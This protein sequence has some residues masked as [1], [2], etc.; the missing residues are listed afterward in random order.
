MRRTL[1]HERR[2]A[3]ASQGG[4]LRK[5]W[6]ILVVPPEQPPL[7]PSPASSSGISLWHGTT[8]R[9]ESGMLLPLEP[10]FA[11]QVQ[12]IAQEFALPSISGL[13]LYL[14]LPNGN[15]HDVPVPSPYSPALSPNFPSSLGTARYD[16]GYST[17]PRLTE[18]TW[19]ILWYDFLYPTSQAGSTSGHFG[20]PIAGRI[21]FDVDPSRARWQPPWLGVPTSD[22]SVDA[23][24]WSTSPRSTSRSAARFGTSRSYARSAT[25][26]WNVA[27]A[28]SHEVSDKSE[29]HPTIDS[30]FN[31]G[32][33]RAGSPLSHR[34]PLSLLSHGSS[35]VRGPSTSR[36]LSRADTPLS[37]PSSPPISPPGSTKPASPTAPADG[38][39]ET[40]DATPRL[41]SDSNVFAFPRPRPTAVSSHTL[42][43]EERV[44]DEST[45]NWTIELD[46]LREVS[47]TSMFENVR[48]DGEDTDEESNTLALRSG[49]T[50]TART[51]EFLETLGSGEREEQDNTDATTTRVLTASGLAISAG[52]PLLPRLSTATYPFL[53]LY[54]P[55]WPHL[56]IYPSLS[57]RIEL[58]LASDAVRALRAEPSTPGFLV[59]DL[60]G[61]ID[62]ERDSD[63]TDVRLSGDAHDEF[64]PN[65]DLVESS[66]DWY[67]SAQG[68]ASEASPGSSSF[69]E[70]EE[71]GM[72]TSTS[73]SDGEG[74]YAI[75][76]GTMLSMIQ[77]ETESRNLTAQM[78]SMRLARL[79]EAERT[80]GRETHVE[81]DDTEREDGAT[82]ST[83]AP[84]A[85]DVPVITVAESC[86]PDRLP[87]T[88]T[89]FADPRVGSPLPSPTITPASGFPPRDDARRSADVYAASDEY[90]FEA[91]DDATEGLPYITS[92]GLEAALGFAGSP[93][94][95]AAF[96]S[97]EIES[98]GTLSEDGS[99]YCP[100][101]RPDDKLLEDDTFGG[102]NDS[103]QTFDHLT[104]LDDVVPPAALDPVLF[105]FPTSDDPD[106]VDALASF[107]V[108]AQGQSIERRGRFTL[109]LG[110]GD[111]PRLFGAALLRD[112]R[113]EWDR[114]EVFFVDGTI[115]AAETSR[116]LW[117]DTLFSH[118]PI[119][120]TRVHH[121]SRLDDRGV[122]ALDEAAIE[123]VAVEYEEELAAA[124]PDCR[125]AGTDPRF[126]LVLLDLDA[127]GNTLSLFPRSPVLD[128]GRWWVAPVTDSPASSLPCIALTFDVLVAARRLAIVA[129]GA[130]KRP[131]VAKTLD[132]SRRQDDL[133]V[134]RLA[135]RD[136]P[137]VYLADEAAV[138][139]LDYPRTQFWE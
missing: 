127:D 79:P 22:R 17:K 136:Q 48:S 50:R 85:H 95:P 5:K 55:V 77:E 72:E 117:M 9:P 97:D 27:R 75:Y 44:P 104:S 94:Y 33:S 21:E 111:L 52:A 4:R 118:V 125:T 43:V 53:Q 80:D 102:A 132:R 10:T 23:S 64:G 73:D 128:D 101:G 124:F 24:T 135:L 20:L 29:R 70:E 129:C 74:L 67:L 2:L 99:Q 30:S 63:A 134:A 6:L 13:C 36:F 38:R 65:G 115:D 11:A 12:L 51:L 139:W 18:A 76:E 60:D 78:E 83:E 14:C 100:G 15:G 40:G 130:S 19:D 3:A 105:T 91:E 69:G 8:S 58:P 42:A 26:S 138:E 119:T 25:P 31:D 39:V 116:R 96:P 41:R 1:E 61:P 88:E 7:S 35:V 68:P 66:I 57:P 32:T 37:R 106:F 46:R 113:V 45:L 126:D 120:S 121:P 131:G 103:C 47:E 54:P 110:A 81:R 62:S 84:P 34:R 86:E 114:W 123:Q 92:P 93:D 59:V 28:G 112:E 137:V 16:A 89:P 133:V 109:A 122:S 90:E 108:Q 71:D 98:D 49:A 56:V 107:V 82:F 87:R